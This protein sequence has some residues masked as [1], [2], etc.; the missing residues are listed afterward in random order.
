MQ[1][2]IIPLSCHS[3]P[4]SDSQKNTRSSQPRES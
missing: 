4:V 2:V 1:H 3:D